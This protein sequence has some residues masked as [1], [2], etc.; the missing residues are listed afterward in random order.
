MISAFHSATLRAEIAPFQRPRVISV[1]LTGQFHAVD[2][3]GPFPEIDLELSSHLIRPDGAKK[4][5]PPDRPEQVA[6]RTLCVTN[7]MVLW[8][9]FQIFWMSL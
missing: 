8:R 9:A 7:T 5:K 1:V 6:S 4:R 3:P 2:V